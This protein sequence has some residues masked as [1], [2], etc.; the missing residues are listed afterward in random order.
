MVSVPAF[1]Q[2]MPYGLMRVPVIEGRP[3]GDAELQSLSAAAREE[4]QRRHEALQDDLK[5]SLKEVRGF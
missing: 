1:L 4:L 5:A 3:M 2:A